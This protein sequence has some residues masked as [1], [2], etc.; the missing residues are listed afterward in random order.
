MTSRFKGGN[1]GIRDDRTKDLGLKCVMMGE[2]G[3]KIA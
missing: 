1:Q 3:S 2:G